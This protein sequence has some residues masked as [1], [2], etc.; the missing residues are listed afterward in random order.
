MTGHDR[1]G[2]AIIETHFAAICKGVW[3]FAAYVVQAPASFRSIITPL[4]HKLPGIIVRP[5]FADIMDSL[6]I[7]PDWSSYGIEGWYAAKH[8][9]VKKGPDK[10]N[11]IRRTAGDINSRNAEDLTDS[12]GIRGI[13]PCS[14]NISK[15][16]A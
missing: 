8:E 12:Y 16:G 10:I 11:G 15:S 6:S 2:D 9:M 1:P 13:G 7:S 4:F 3:A 14:L 5:A